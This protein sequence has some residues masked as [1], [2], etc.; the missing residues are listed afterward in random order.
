VREREAV[1][2]VGRRELGVAAVDLIA[3]ESRRVAEVLLAARAEFAASTARA[4]PGNPE[5]RPRCDRDARAGGD[6]FSD[7]LVAGHERRT[8]RLELAVDVQIG[9]A[10]RARAHPEEHLSVRRHRNGPLLQLEWRAGSGE[11]HRPHSRTSIAYGVTMAR[12]TD[13]AQRTS[14]AG[15]VVAHHLTDQWQ[16][17]PARSATP[18]IAGSVSPV[19]GVSMV[20]ET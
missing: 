20:Y 16:D 17:A 5:P 10:D 11:D 15:S 2:L 7:D 12:S 4:E 19:P 13:T 6:D 3:G 18:G 8:H 1:A 9:A 14:A